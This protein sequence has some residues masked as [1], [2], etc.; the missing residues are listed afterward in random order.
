LRIPDIEFELDPGTLGGKFTTVEGMLQNI[1]DELES[2]APFSRGDSSTA[3]ER[4]KLEHFLSR[5]NKLIALETPFTLII[6]DPLG[7]SYVQNINA[8]DPDPNMT[9]EEYDR[10]WEQNE[11]F[12]LNDMNTSDNYDEKD[13]NNDNQ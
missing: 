4:E 12:G 8:P 10:T 6:D 9:V 11:A 13:S 5:L 2:K 7:N 3:A 1:H